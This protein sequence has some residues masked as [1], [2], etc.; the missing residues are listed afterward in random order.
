ME[1]YE[2]E[3]MLYEQLNSNI[4]AFCQEN[5]LTYCQVIGVCQMLINELSEE[6]KNINQNEED[7]E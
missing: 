6:M 4:D 2:K 5:D 1:P 7:E 3:Q